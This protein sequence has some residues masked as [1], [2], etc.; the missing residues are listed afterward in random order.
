MEGK[1]LISMMPQK[2]YGAF[3]RIALIERY[4]CDALSQQPLN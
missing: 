3:L 2:G 1:Q 4:Q